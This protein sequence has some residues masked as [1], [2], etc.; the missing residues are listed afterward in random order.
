MSSMPPRF[1]GH[2][3]V[4]RAPDGRTAR[5]RSTAR[6][7]ALDESMVV[8]ADEHGPES[9]AGIMGGEASGCD[10]NTTDVLIE[11]ALWDPI[12]IAQTGRKL[13]IN[14][15]ARY[16]FERGVDPA[17]CRPRTGSCNRSSCST[18]A[19]A[20]LR[21]SPSPGPF[22]CPDLRVDFPLSEV[23]RLTGLELPASDAQR[24]L[25]RLGFDLLGHPDNSDWI[26]AQAPSWR[27][28]IHGKA[29]LVEEI[30]RI[31]GLDQLVAQP[32]DARPRRSPPRADAA[33]EADPIG[34]ADARRMRP[35]RGR[36]LVVRVRGPGEGFRGR[37]ARTRLGQ[38]DRS[39]AFDHAAE[40][41]AGIDRSG[42]TQ[43]R[44]GAFPTPR[45][46]RSD[47]SFSAMAR[48]TSGSRRRACAAAR[49]AP[50]GR[51]GIGPGRRLRS[52]CS[53]ARLTP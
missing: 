33:S 51:G 32:L 38:P 48:A 43:R 11:S 8:I 30:L 15:D 23:V 36:D 28:D 20:R 44:H 41:P 19:A 5:G 7:Y 1:M 49:H 21:R 10:E 39:R 26:V 9:L 47:R 45:C 6:I 22:P 13:G 3:V 50:P 29:D 27:P 42:G 35:S 34:E 40:P 2:L 18:S 46:S 16:R 17:F 4:R 12:T 24:I 37:S 53:T 31:A 25:E 14:T 52:V